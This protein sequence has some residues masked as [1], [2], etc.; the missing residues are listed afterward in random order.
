MPIL[1]DDSAPAHQRLVAGPRSRWMHVLGAGVTNPI[2]S[3]F[4]RP[5]FDKKFAIGGRDSGYVIGSCFAQQ[6]QFALGRRKTPLRS[7]ILEA[8]TREWFVQDD[9]HYWPLHFFHRFNPCSMLQEFEHI[10]SLAPLIPDGA[11]IF[12][13]PDS[14]YAD[15]HYD[16]RFVLDSPEECLARRRFIHQSINGL[17]GVDFVILTLGLIEAWID[18][19][20]GLY[21]NTPPTPELLA[22]DGSRFGFQVLAESDVFEAISRIF[23]LLYAL[24][25]GMKIVITVSPIPL[26]ATFTGQDISI[27]NAN[28][29][30]TLLCA[31]HRLLRAYP[32]V[33][34]FPAYE[35]VTLSDRRSVWEPDGRHVRGDFVERV[36][37]LFCAEVMDDE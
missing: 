1:N 19:E 34:Y 21:L 10:L 37:D 2:G 17:V 5:K 23:E 9:A 8:P 14:R 32:G 35:I 28:S 13:R 20:S 29:K 24:N 36:M 6:V 18:R 15:C 26:G 27:A 11:L 4:F 22:L 7:S 31:T 16:S 33:L 25:E 30:A 3:D 12:K